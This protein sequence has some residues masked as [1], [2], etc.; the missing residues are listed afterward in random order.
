[1][2]CSPFWVGE[3]GRTRGLAS[4]DLGGPPQAVLGSLPCGDQCGCEAWVGVRGERA[5]EAAEVART[6]FAPRALRA[7]IPPVGVAELKSIWPPG[8]REMASPG[9]FSS[10]VVC[11][12]PSLLT[13]TFVACAF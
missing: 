11:T 9:I 2:P 12:P 7:G 1:M 3:R 13:L 5:A 8:L 4:S 10:A 6:V